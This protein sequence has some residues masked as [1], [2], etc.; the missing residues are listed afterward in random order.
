[1]DFVAKLKL[2][3]FRSLKTKFYIPYIFCQKTMATHNKTFIC[4][5][6]NSN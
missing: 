2:T 3:V 6:E 4:A 1:M 5:L